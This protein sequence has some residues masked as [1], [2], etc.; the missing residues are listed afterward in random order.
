MRPG[1]WAALAVADFRERARRPAYAIVLLAAVGLGYLAVPAAGDH[2]TIVNA[3]SYRGVYNSAYVGTVTAL[4]GALWLSAGGFYVIRTAVARDRQTGVGELL[5]ATPMRT[6]DY[7]I[8]KFLSNFLV[9]ASMA[10]ALAV[11]ALAMQLARGESRAVDVVALLTPFLLCTLPV[12]AVCAAAAIVFETTPVLRGGLGNIIWLFVSLVAVIAGQSG[13]APLGGLGVNAFA[14]SLRGDLAAQGFKVTD[15][16]LG[17]MYLDSPPRPVPWSGVD[18]TAAFAAQRLLLVT[19]AAAVALLPAFWFDRFDRA[20]RHTGTPRFTMTPPDHGAALTAGIAPPDVTQPPATTVQ[21]PGITRLAQLEGGPARRGWGFGRVVVGEVRILIG[22]V[23]KWWWL[24]TLALVVAGIAAPAASSGLLAAAWIWP[25]LIW[26]RLGCQA[27]EHGAEGLLDACPG[28][29]VRV[30]AQ[31]L[32][33]VALTAVVGIGPGLAMAVDGRLA[34]WLAGALFIPALAL[35]LGVISR[36]QRFFQAVYPLLW[37]LVI[38]DVGG[39]DYMGLLPDGPRPGTV[40]TATTLLLVS[41]LTAVGV[42]QR[43]R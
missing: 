7:L 24:A 13:N 26:S 39:L 4:A 34:E 43:L 16:A 40:V 23:S 27:R 32:S 18:F 35:A 15:L 5:A 19:L 3:G 17:L 29:V 1:T 37:Y 30:L 12:L 20:R 33:G 36:T 28:P 10:A 38:N 6:V 14:E 25:V 11:A 2:W 42:R 9:L 22:G 31:W 8:G 41:A 21:V